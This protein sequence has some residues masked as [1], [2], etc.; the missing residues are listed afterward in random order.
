GADVPRL[1]GATK[2]QLK[3]EYAPHEIQARTLGIPSVGI[4][5]IYTVPERDFVIDPI[6][7]PDHWP[8]VCALDPGWNR[9][10]ALW[11]AWDQEADCVYLYSE[12]YRG[13]AE[14]E[15]HA[16]AIKARGIR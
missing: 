5:S 8:R 3:S 13:Y 1:D 9:T 2:K 10:A 7:L 6:P 14:V 15:V 4:G 12:H 16:A 11:G